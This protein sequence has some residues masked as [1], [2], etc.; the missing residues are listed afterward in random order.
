M[1]KEYVD[2]LPEHLTRRFISAEEDAVVVTGRIPDIDASEL[3]PVIETLDAALDDGA[4]GASRLRRSPSPASSAIA[5]RN[6]AGM[7]G[8]LNQRADDRDRLRR[9][10]HRHRLPLRRS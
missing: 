8:K 9:G 3:L 7:I 2:V 5:A 10:L 6:S 4:R 1:L